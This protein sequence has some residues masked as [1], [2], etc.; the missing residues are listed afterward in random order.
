MLLS[1][2]VRSLSCSGRLGLYFSYGI[3]LGMT[4]LGGMWAMMPFQRRWPFR[5]A[6]GWHWRGEAG[7]G[8]HPGD[9]RRPTETGRAARRDAL[10]TAHALQ[11][12]FA[13]AEH[14]VLV[15]QATHEMLVNKRQ[16]RHL[17]I[18]QAIAVFLTIG[19]S[20]RVPQCRRSP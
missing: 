4:G 15:A 14:E 7:D 18:P 5:L 13:R 10:H 19:S 16:R 20:Q 3:P 17:S 8:G 2:Q 9:G 1:G 11:L 12:L 6:S